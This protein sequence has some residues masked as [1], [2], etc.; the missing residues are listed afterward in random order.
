[1]LP[2]SVAFASYSAWESPAPPVPTAQDASPTVAR[3]AVTANAALVLFEL[4]M[5]TPFVPPEKSAGGEKI[6]RQNRF[7]EGVD[8][9]AAAT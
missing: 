2:E 5:T 7:S 8:V 6:R 4:R 1:M 3:T 9:S